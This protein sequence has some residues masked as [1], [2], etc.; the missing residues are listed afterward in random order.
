MEPVRIAIRVTSAVVEHFFAWVFC[1]SCGHRE[2]QEIPPDIAMAIKRGDGAEAACTRCGQ[3]LLAV[4]R[5]VL[6]PQEAAAELA[7]AQAQARARRDLTGGVPITHHRP[8]E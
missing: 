6:T 2:Q 5:A 3:P 7:E 4:E 1:P 8:E